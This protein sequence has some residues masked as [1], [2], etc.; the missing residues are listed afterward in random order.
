MKFIKQVIINKNNIYFNFTSKYKINKNGLIFFGNP[1]YRNID[2]VTQKNIDKHIHYIS[3]VFMCLFI[4]KDNFFIY[5][6]IGGN[7]RIYYKKLKNKTIITDNYQILLKNKITLNHEQFKFWNEKNYTIGSKTLFNEINKIPPSTKTFIKK[8][9]VTHKIYFDSNYLKIEGNLKSILEK[10][11]NKNLINLKNTK[12]KNILLFSGGKD[13]SLLAQILKKKG[14]KYIPV[15][16][17]TNQ[18]FLELENN[19]INALNVAKKNKIKLF[20]INI[21]LEKINEKDIINEMLFDFHLSFLHYEG[22]KKIKKKFGKKLNIIC[23][24]SADSIFSFGA[25]ANTISHFVSRLSYFYNNIILS[26]LIRIILQNKYKKKLLFL[27]IKKEYLFFFSFYYYM[28]IDKILYF[29]S[30]GIK[31]IIDNLKNKF[32]NKNDFYMYLKIFGFLQGSDNQV[33]V[34]SCKKYNANVV[35]PYLDP[36]LVYGVIKKKNIIKDLFFPKYPITDLLKETYKLKKIRKTHI[37]KLHNNN[38]KSIEKNLK[39]KFKNKIV[40]LINK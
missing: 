33:V 1:I 4:N 20:Q 24:Q 39:Y 40:S 38:L 19:K 12:F 27:N 8:N 18:K 11:I 5:N 26:F 36:Q 23:G 6:D 10:C 30:T 28:F 9:V 14:V 17:N 7:Y 32:N 22:I 2:H 25:S 3:G 35:M 15:I 21:D 16:L 37:S 34:N 31:K 13:S 29:R